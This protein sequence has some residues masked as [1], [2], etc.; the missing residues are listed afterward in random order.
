MQF[1]GLCAIVHVGCRGIVGI[2]VAWRHTYLT[3]KSISRDASTVD[4]LIWRRDRSSIMLNIDKK[5]KAHQVGGTLHRMVHAVRIWWGKLGVPCEGRSLGS[6]PQT[7]Y[8]SS[9]LEN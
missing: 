6:F 7:Y 8:S 1:A 5:D 4:T 9:G 2:V 3:H